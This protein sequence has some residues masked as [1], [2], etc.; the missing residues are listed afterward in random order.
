MYT[1]LKA[2]SG[3]LEQ[4]SDGAIVYVFSAAQLTWLDLA[5]GRKGRVVEQPHG[6]VV[7]VLPF[8]HGSV[9]LCKVVGVL[10][11]GKDTNYKLMNILIQ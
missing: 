6:G 2:S 1:D 7:V 8:A 3:V 5:I 10:K 4:Q 11:R 9:G